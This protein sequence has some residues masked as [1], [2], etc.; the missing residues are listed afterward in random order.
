MRHHFIHILSYSL[1]LYCLLTGTTIAMFLFIS[2]KQ[3]APESSIQRLSTFK[4][5]IYHEFNTRTYI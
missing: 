4:F 2:S 5:T 3:T 1:L